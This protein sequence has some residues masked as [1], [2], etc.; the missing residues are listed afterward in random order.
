MTTM[1]RNR[2]AYLG[3]IPITVFIAAFLLSALSLQIETGSLNPA[4]IFDLASASG[5]QALLL[6]HGWVPRFLISLVAGAGLAT[7]GALFQHT[8]KNPL[9]APSTLGLA[10][11]A[12]AWGFFAFMRMAANSAYPTFHF[13][14]LHWKFI[15]AS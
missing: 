3:P 1:L 9:A 8:L 4:I 5:T 11:G 12:K 7:A 2:S 13:C 15:N 10:G 6:T 14:F